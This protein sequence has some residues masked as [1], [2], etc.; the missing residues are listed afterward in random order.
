M[1]TTR[2][3]GP[4]VTAVVDGIDETAAVAEDEWPERG[5]F[6]E[7]F[8]NRKFFYKEQLFRNNLK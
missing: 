5:V 4:G 8:L 1:S 6:E 7:I 3:N 2:S